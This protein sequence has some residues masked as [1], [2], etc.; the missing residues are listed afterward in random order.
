MTR[1]AKTWQRICV[2][3]FE[4]RLNKALKNGV[5]FSRRIELTIP[6]FPFVFHLSPSFELCIGT[7]DVKIRLLSSYILIVETMAKNSHFILDR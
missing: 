1:R 5:R 7:E 3:R 4:R 2:L 6:R